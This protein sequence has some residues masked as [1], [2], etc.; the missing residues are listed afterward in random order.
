MK[1]YLFILAFTAIGFQLKAQQAVTFS[2]QADMDDWQ[3]YMSSKLMG[4]LRMGNKLVFITVTAGDEGNGSNTF[5]NS[6]VPFYIARERGS[7]Y[8]SK[9]AADITGS[10]PDSVPALQRIIVNNKSLVKYVYRNT[11]NYFLRLPAG[12]SG[13][14]GYEN[15]GYKSLRKFKQASIGSLKS[16]DGITT[17]NNWAEL[18]N[19]IKQI[20]ITEKGTNSQVWMNVSSLNTTTNPNELSDRQYASRAAQE[21][22][23]NLTWVGINEFVMAHSQNLS[24]N[25]NNSDHE[26]S[27]VLFGIS[28]WGMLQYKYSGYYLNTF[29][30]ML[31]MEY[32]SIKRIPSGNA[33]TSAPNGANVLM[34]GLQNQSSSITN[35][36]NIAASDVAED[37][38]LQMPMAISITSPVAVGGTI[39]MRMSHYETGM[40]ITTVYN[41]SGNQV[42][43]KATKV[44]VKGFMIISFTNPALTS[45]VY[46]VKNVLN[47]KFIETRKI[48]VD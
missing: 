23:S 20:I 22:V 46:F 10:I 39:N 48:V 2:I 36:G 27:T 41:I 15:T 11:V 8:T 29:K 16:V 14:N 33:P 35:S 28:V 7:V 1:K 9:F 37:G 47:N 31:P 13:G 21:A 44:T 19:T 43:Q 25:L 30:A 32:F 3:M 6:S 12:G 42:F 24:A 5:N 26:E 45:G 40:L 4:D 34:A 17:Y 18:T 38:L